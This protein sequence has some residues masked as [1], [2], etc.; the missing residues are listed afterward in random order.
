MSIPWPSLP[1]VTPFLL[2]YAVHSTLLLVCAWTADRLLGEERAATREGLWRFALLGGLLSASLQLGLGIEPIAGRLEL[3]GQQISPM[4]TAPQRW[5]PATAG[6]RPEAQASEPRPLPRPDSAE[7]PGRSSP[8]IVTA[9]ERVIASPAQIL[10]AAWLLV[11]GVLLLR[12]VSGHLRLHRRL[13]DRRPIGGRLRSRLDELIALAGLPGPVVLSESARL[14]VPLALGIGRREICL[15]R[16]ALCQLDDAEQDAVLAHELA[17]LRRRDPRWQLLARLVESLFFFQPLNGKARRRLQDLA[18]LRADDWATA[19]LDCELDLARCLATV[20]G[21]QLATPCGATTTLAAHRSQ[22]RRRIERLLA[23][24]DKGVSM[25][26]SRTSPWLVAAATAVVVLACFAAPGVSLTQAPAPPAP[27]PSAAPG[28][29]PA[30]VAAPAILPQPATAATP[31]APRPASMAQPVP[32]APPPPA[33]RTEAQARRRS[34]RASPEL[35]AE[36]E[37]ELEAVEES[38]AEVERY[39]EEALAPLHEEIEAHLQEV[40]I[41]LERTIEPALHELEEVI[42]GAVEEAL[43]AEELSPMVQDRLRA[44]QDVMAELQPSIQRVVDAATRMHEP[45]HG[46]LASTLHDLTHGL[47]HRRFRE[48]MKRLAHAG[49]AL[50]EAERQALYDELRRTI[51][52]GRPS[53]E[54]LAALR[55]RVRSTVEAAR[56]PREEMDALRTDIETALETVRRRLGEERENLDRERAE[57]PQ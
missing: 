5:R 10:T 44:V 35:D 50:D 13:A 40:E 49:S 7:T 14:S 19:T 43:E 9:G 57:Q 42:D 30:P 32:P 53:A 46:E 36:L 11:A 39:L 18:E 37:E 4:T 8:T 52:E 31:A 48:L 29:P 1:A 15:P 38:L 6:S 20:A 3:P 51:E 45:L 12:L 24:R 41:E 26:P 25:P 28:P 17:H 22:L 23:H 21:W 34:E 16:E 2:T 54:E 47:D 27:E 55:E 33:P 56:L